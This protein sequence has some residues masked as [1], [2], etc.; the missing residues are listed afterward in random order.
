MP[1]PENLIKNIAANKNVIDDI[2]EKK[3][4]EKERSNVTKNANL[5]I[6]ISSIF[7]PTKIKRKLL[8]KVAEA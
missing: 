8:N 6:L 3:K 5:K 2:F 7:F 1:C 4:Q